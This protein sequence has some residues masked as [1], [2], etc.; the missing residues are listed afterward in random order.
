VASRD[1]FGEF[2]WREN[3]G[4]LSEPADE[5]K[6]ETERKQLDVLATSILWARIEPS[7]C[8]GSYHESYEIVGVVGDVH[9]KSLDK[10]AN[11]GVFIANLQEA[12]GPVNL[13]V[14]THGDPKQLASAIRAE[15]HALDR[16]MPIAAVRTMDEYVSDSVAAPRFNT[17]LLGGFAALA[18]VLAAVG[19]FGVISYSVAQR[20]Q[21]IGI[22]RALGADT[23]SVMRQVVLQGML[24]SVIGET[25]GVGGA[26]AVT[27]LL[28]S[29][30][31]EVTPVDP[32]TFVVVAVVLLLVAL[33][34]TILPARRA[35]KIDPMVALRYE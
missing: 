27:R 15:I 16:E 31:F 8:R 26:L 21:E 14:G 20:T 28:G 13:V 3:I 7:D 17:I 22:R 4:R 30:L 19:I 32:T 10:E 33:L 11:P 1:L 34:A 5:E 9:Q 35:A 12:T 23:G 24:L 29:L 6:A 25:F 2:L 18:L